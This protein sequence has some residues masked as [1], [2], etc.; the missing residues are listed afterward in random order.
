VTLQPGEDG[1]ELRLL[2][3]IGVRGPG[4]RFNC[5]AWAAKRSNS[6]TGQSPAIDLLCTLTHSHPLLRFCHHVCYDNFAMSALILT[7]DLQAVLPGKLA[8]RGIQGNQ[9]A[10][11]GSCKRLVCNDL[12]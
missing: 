11:C 7:G 4:H 1:V 9:C 10:V 8:V 6:A 5:E 3:G 2:S 12:S